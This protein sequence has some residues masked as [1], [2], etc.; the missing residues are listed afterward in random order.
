MIRRST[1]DPVQGTIQQIKIPFRIHL[2]DLS[3]SLCG[4]GMVVNTRHEAARGRADVTE[5]V[6]HWADGEGVSLASLAGVKAVL[7]VV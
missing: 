4:P 5:E 2:S 6:A 7:A 3:R 1:T